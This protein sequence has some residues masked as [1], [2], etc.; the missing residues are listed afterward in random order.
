MALGVRDADAYVCA[1]AHT[2]TW[3]SELVCVCVCVCVC[4]YVCVCVCVTTSTFLRVCCVL[5]QNRI[6]SRWT[7]VLR[8]FNVTQVVNAVK[9]WPPSHL[10]PTR[11][12]DQ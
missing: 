12:C 2:H 6:Y 11:W 7:H 8:G 4:L 1:R 5:G 3:L 9:T 10:T